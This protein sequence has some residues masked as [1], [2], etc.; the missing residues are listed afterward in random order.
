MGH[1]PRRTAASLAAEGAGPLTFIPSGSEG[2]VRASY[3]PV[4]KPVNAAISQAV[5]PNVSVDTP[6][7]GRIQWAVFVHFPATV[8]RANVNEI[9]LGKEPMTH[10]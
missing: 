4:A 1:R 9:I 8:T 2:I 7:R 3:S 6:R 5:R 10:E